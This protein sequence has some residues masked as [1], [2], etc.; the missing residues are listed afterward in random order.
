LKEEGREMLEN[1][2][3]KLKED[4]ESLIEKFKLK[5]NLIAD[6]KKEEKSKNAEV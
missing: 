2:L 5:K 6:C 1:R 3:K 4:V